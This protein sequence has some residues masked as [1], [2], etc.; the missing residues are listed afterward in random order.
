MKKKTTAASTPVAPS[1]TATAVEPV[2]NTQ[3]IPRAIL[4]C[5]VGLAVWWFALK[6]AS[7]YLLF[8]AA[9]VPLLFAISPSG[10]KPIVINEQTHEWNF[11]IALNMNVPDPATGKM[12]HLGSI[13]YG[14]T[15]D[16]IAYFVSGWVVYLALSFAAGG[17]AKD[18]LMSTLKG[19]GLQVVLSIVALAVYA[20]VN[21]YGS[22][23]S[24][25]GDKQTVWWIRWVYHV[26]YLVV[27]FIGPFVIALFMHRPWRDYLLPKLPARF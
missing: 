20:Y 26:D 10:F 11:N 7:L 13:E 17:F 24:E 19:F 18:R 6:R 25:L 21:G 3:L 2:G 14:T 22:A 8:L 15:E 12:G 5:V 23:Y 9:Y 4:S 1:A 16:S 27:P